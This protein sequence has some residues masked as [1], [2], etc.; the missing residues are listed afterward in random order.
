MNIDKL[1]SDPI[2]LAAGVVIVVA[3]VYYLARRTVVDTVQGSA[4]IV[5]GVLSGNNAVTKDTP[6]ENKGTVGTVAAVTDRLLG[7]LPQVIG[8]QISSWFFPSVN[9]TGN[10]YYNVGF[11][12]GS[13]HAIRDDLV[14]KS[15]F[16]TYGGKR[17]RLGITQDNRRVAVAA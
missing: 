10:L 13:R 12:D 1:F 2:R 6:Y 14:D 4:N 9:P 15:G 8:S 11:P 5:G 16:F 7:G 17:Y 3:T